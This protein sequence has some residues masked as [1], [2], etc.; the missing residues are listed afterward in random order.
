MIAIIDVETTGLDPHSNQVIEFACIL[1]DPRNGHVARFERV[2]WHDMLLGNPIALS[3]N[4]RILRILSNAAKTDSI[5]K[6]GVIHANNLESEFLSWLVSE[7]PAIAGRVSKGE[8]V[9]LTGCGKNVAAFDIPFLKCIFDR[10]KL[11][12]R[13]RSLDVGSLCYRPALHH[14]Q[15]PDLQNCL[16]TLGIDHKVDHTALGDCEA[17]LKILQATYGK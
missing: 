15:L 12:F 3:M 9:S 14:D 7:D 4:A 8:C 11:K 6:G 1:W 10:A 2:L 16:E 13:H 17:V 5:G